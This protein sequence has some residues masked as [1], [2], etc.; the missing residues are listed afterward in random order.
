MC[1]GI[2]FGQHVSSFNCNTVFISNWKMKTRAQKKWRLSPPWIYGCLSHIYGDLT[3]EWL[4]SAWLIRSNCSNSTCGMKMREF[5]TFIPRQWHIF[6]L[7]S[8]PHVCN[9]RRMWLR[10]N[11]CRFTCQVSCSPSRCAWWFWQS[12]SDKNNIHSDPNT[13]FSQQ[14]FVN[15]NQSE[16]Y[17]D[18]CPGLWKGTIKSTNN[19]TNKHNEV[20]HII[21]EI[22]KR[23]RDDLNT[24]FDKFHFYILT[25]CLKWQKEG[26]T[27]S[28]F[29]VT[30]QTKKLDLKCEL[31]LI[32]FIFLTTNTNFS[33]FFLFATIFV[34]SFWITKKPPFFL[35]LLLTTVF[36]I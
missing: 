14:K 17:F 7:S 3:V 31:N 32:W 19:W 35:I 12:N 1:R 2:C 4:R 21:S 29:E 26:W 18:C 24:F 27:V 25:G 11:T 6:L 33:P 30:L 28:N 13:T 10:N 16:C 34:S 5:S 9:K 23:D 22:L 36:S 20:K 15:Q 8:K